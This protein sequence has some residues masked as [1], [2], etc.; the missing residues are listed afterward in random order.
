MSRQW[1]EFATTRFEMGSN[2]LAGR[3]DDDEGPPRNVTVGSM[4]I[5]PCITVGEFADFVAA[6]GYRTTAET[7]GTGWVGDDGGGEWTTGASWQNPDGSG[8]LIDATAAVTQVSWYDCQEFCRWSG[9]GLPTEAQWS[10]AAFAD[11]SIASGIWQWCGD[12]YHPTFHRTEQRVNPTGPIAGT[13]R[14]L[15]GGGEVRTQRAHHLP[16]FSSNHTAFRAAGRPGT[17]RV[18]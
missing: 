3:P 16:D 11:D 1:I 17:D 14:V 13:E 10:R 18:L 9:T 5:S 7:E 6:T 12:F 4:A 15:R 8:E 2:R